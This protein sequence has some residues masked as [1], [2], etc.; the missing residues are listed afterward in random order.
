[1]DIKYNTNFSGFIPELAFSLHTD[2]PNLNHFAVRNIGV[3][4]DFGS[5]HALSLVS[6]ISNHFPNQNINLYK[7]NSPYDLI[8]STKDLRIP[9]T[10]CTLVKISDFLTMRDIAAIYNEIHIEN[11]LDVTKIH[12]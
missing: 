1:M 12:K 5:S 7:E 10:N 3:Y 9:N 4:S 2:I 8:I 6:S 11:K